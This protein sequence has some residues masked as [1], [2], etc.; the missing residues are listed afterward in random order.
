LSDGA[1]SQR[2][3]GP[4]RSARRSRARRS[5]AL[6]PMSPSAKRP[7]VRWHQERLL[8]ITR[9]EVR[10][11][12]P[13]KCLNLGFARHPP[14]GAVASLPLLKRLSSRA[15]RRRRSRPPQART[16]VQGQ[17]PLSQAKR[18]TA[19]EA[20]TSSLGSLPRI[21]RLARKPGDHGELLVTVAAR[22]PQFLRV[23][24]TVNTRTTIKT[25]GCVGLSS[26]SGRAC[27]GA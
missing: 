21:G 4:S 10:G 1:C 15:R 8:T 12:M 19:L 18:R 27:V 14:S 13:L 26:A 20:A 3:S 25:Y 6:P 22:R 2:Y 11:L 9:Q 7:R 5:L 16:P 24:G 23:L 17:I